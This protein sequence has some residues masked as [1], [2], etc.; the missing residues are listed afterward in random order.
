[1]A[2]ATVGAEIPGSG[3]ER[4]GPTTTL[5]QPGH[6][7][8][9]LAGHGYCF[10]VLRKSANSSGVMVNGARPASRDTLATRQVKEVGWR[11]FLFMERLDKGSG[12]ETVNSGLTNVGQCVQW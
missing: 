10:A 1:M 6:W 12:Y 5:G 11:R 4:G 8:R 3:L 2:N 7:P 9:M